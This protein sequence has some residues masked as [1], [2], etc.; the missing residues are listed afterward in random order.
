MRDRC[1]GGAGGSQPRTPDAASPGRRSG[2][3]R[4]RPGRSAARTDGAAPACDDQRP[5]VAEPHAGHGT[6]VA[7]PDQRKL[8]EDIRTGEHTQARRSIV[9]PVRKGRYCRAERGRVSRHFEQIAA[10]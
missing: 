7:N 3:G 6:C 1:S 10:S 5:Q 8:T 9:M 2:R 4:I